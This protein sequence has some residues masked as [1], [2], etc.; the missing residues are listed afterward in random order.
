MTLWRSRIVP[1]TCWPKFAG[2]CLSR[3]A[4]ME[5]SRYRSAIGHVRL[6]ACC[7]WYRTTEPGQFAT[8]S[9]HSQIGRLV[10]LLRA[11]AGLDQAEEPQRASDEEGSRRGLGPVTMREFANQKVHVARSLRARCGGRSWFAQAESR[12]GGVWRR[13][14]KRASDH[15]WVHEDQRLAVASW[16]ISQTNRSKLVHAPLARL[17]C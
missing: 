5:G 9:P 11:L 4:A 2:F 12:F 15:L 10:L 1:V 6:R 8:A 3:L 16:R 17:R 14:G 13:K 7:K